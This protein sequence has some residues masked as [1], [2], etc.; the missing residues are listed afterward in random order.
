MKTMIGSWSKGT[1]GVIL[2]VFNS[3]KHL[4]DGLNRFYRRFDNHDFSGQINEMK[5]TFFFFN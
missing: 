2:D 4:A 3:A 5:K 1:G